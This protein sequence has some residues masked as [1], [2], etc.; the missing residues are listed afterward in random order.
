MTSYH[1]N[2]GWS[3]KKNYFLVLDSGYSLEYIIMDDYLN[4]LMRARS[5]RILGLA[6]R[7]SVRTRCRAPNINQG[8][9]L[10]IIRIILTKRA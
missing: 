5:L 8:N 9:C 4:S 10:G 3:I 6:C 7:A 1:R 2:Y